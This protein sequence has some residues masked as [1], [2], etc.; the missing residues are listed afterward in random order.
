MKAIGVKWR[1]G[2]HRKALHHYWRHEAELR[3]RQALLEG[4]LKLH[5]GDSLLRQIERSLHAYYASIT[6]MVLSDR[7]AV[8]PYA[9]IAY[10]CAMRAT[11]HLDEVA[12]LPE[13]PTPEERKAWRNSQYNP[14]NN[15]GNQ[16]SNAS[17][18]MQLT[19]I[20]LSL[21]Y[22][23]T[24]QLHEKRDRSVVGKRL[25]SINDYVNGVIFL[26]ATAGES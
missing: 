21:M 14:W 18:V 3:A 13:P 23:L 5:Y 6:A 7:Q 11:Q 24:M 25:R 17:A 26:Y 22:P 1:W 12:H 20:S 15:A 10:K 4:D 2:K 8:A 9:K 16:A 19:S